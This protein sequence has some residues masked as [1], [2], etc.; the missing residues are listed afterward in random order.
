MVR[1]GDNKI[2]ALLENSGVREI[3]FGTVTV[4]KIDEDMDGDGVDNLEDAFAF[5]PS[6]SI[7]TDNDGTGNNADLD[8]DGDG[9]SDEDEIAAGRDPLDSSD[10]VNITRV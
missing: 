5:D 8:D 3:L 7:D 9:M 2:I 10:A 4:N 6:E 1:I